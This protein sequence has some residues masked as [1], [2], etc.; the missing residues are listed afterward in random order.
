MEAEF[1]NFISR[2]HYAMC[3]A[4]ALVSSSEV[5]SGMFLSRM[6]SD[7]FFCI[8]GTKTFGIPDKKIVSL[9]QGV[10]VNQG[11]EISRFS[12]FALFLMQWP[13][14][15][16]VKSLISGF[17]NLCQRTTRDFLICASVDR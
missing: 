10:R 13:S 14:S 7:N 11:D 9:S 15:D 8:L 17:L 12:S 5:R 1:W 3:A 6:I 4:S 16:H 2:V